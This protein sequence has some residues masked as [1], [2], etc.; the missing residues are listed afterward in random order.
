MSV[1]GTGCGRTVNN[2]R[3]SSVSGLSGATFWVVWPPEGD[4]LMGFEQS[5]II[6]W[7][8]L[9]GTSPGQGFEDDDE[10]EPMVPPIGRAVPRGRQQVSSSRGE[11]PRG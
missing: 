11:G 10:D 8:L 1:G 3:R 7:V 6:S 2:Q 5:V 4:H 9:R